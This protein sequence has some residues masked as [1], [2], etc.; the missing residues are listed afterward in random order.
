MKITGSKLGGTRRTGAASAA[1][2]P[3]GGQAFSIQSGASAREAPAAA[4]SAGV[5]PVNSLDALIAL[6]QVDGPLERRRRAMNRAGRILDVLDQVQIA[7][8]DGEPDSG[9]LAKLTKA[10]REE[11]A[12]TEDPRLEGLL[13]EI[14]TRAAVE[15]AKREVSLS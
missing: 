13:D 7:L 3:P 12:G 2:Q 1:G 6:Q 10:V 9:S 14:E 15:M 11:R 4:R 8:L 5:G